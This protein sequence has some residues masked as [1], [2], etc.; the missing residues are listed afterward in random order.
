MRLALVRT[1]PAAP[2]AASRFYL[3]HTWSTTLLEDGVYQLDVEAI[4]LRGNKGSRQLRFRIAN[5]V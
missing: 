5:N 3:A 2:G 4:D 1:A